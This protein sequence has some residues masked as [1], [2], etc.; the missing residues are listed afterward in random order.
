MTSL[1]IREIKNRDSFLHNFLKF[2]ANSVFANFYCPAISFFICTKRWK[3][4]YKMSEKWIR[5]TTKIW[6]KTLL[7]IDF[8]VKGF[9][10]STTKNLR[11][12][13]QINVVFDF[14]SI[15]ISCFVVDQ[16]IYKTNRLLFEFLGE[17]D[18]K[19]LAWIIDNWRFLLETKA[20]YTVWKNNSNCIPRNIIDEK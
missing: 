9:S 12:M 8:S 17:I 13:K 15:L 16:R 7:N 19:W 5:M 14:T 11:Q 10:I 1:F 6:L 2:I 4:E 3:N 18:K 20:I